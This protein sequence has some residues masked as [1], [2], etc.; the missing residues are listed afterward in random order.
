MDGLLCTACKITVSSQNESKAHYKSEFHTYNLK[1]K[2]VKLEPASYETFCEKKQQSQ[3]LAASSGESAHCT[4]CGHSF[5]S[6]QTLE[7]H[8]AAQ[9]Q[10]AARRLGPSR[11]ND[12]AL[13][14]VFCSSTSESLDSNLQHMLRVHSFCVPD[15]EFVRD[16][17]RLL[18]YLQDKVHVGLMCVYCNSR[19]FSSPSAVQQHMSDKQH[20]FLSAEE[21]Y[22]QFY[23][24]GAVELAEAQE[25]L[26]AEL[27]VDMG[28]FTSNSSLTEAAPV[29]NS[30]LP[31]VLARTGELRLETGKLLGHRQYA[32]YYKQHFRPHTKHEE[33]LSALAAEYRALPQAN[34]GWRDKHMKPK[35]VRPEKLKN[36]A[37]LKRNDLNRF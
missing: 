9:E 2:L 31:G 15:I 5:R 1:R 10:R 24:W 35:E 28:S 7:K 18:E 22:E 4:C 6:Q 36:R 21:E 3:L 13:S 8:L 23:A 29:K 34:I 37:D 25:E 12:P 30:I 11:V 16:I 19:G 27:Y 20:M 33:S 14:C 17:E 26:G 32:R